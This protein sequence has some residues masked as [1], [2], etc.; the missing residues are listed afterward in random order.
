MVHASLLSYSLPSTV[1]LHPSHTY[2]LSVPRLTHTPISHCLL[3]LPLLPS[4]VFPPPLPYL[5]SHVFSP[6]A[7]HL[8]HPPRAR[9]IHYPKN[10][11]EQHREMPPDR[12]NRHFVALFLTRCALLHAGTCTAY[13][14]VFIFVPP[15]VGNRQTLDWTDRTDLMNAVWCRAWFVWLARITRQRTCGAYLPNHTVAGI[16]AHWRLFATAL[17]GQP[18]FCACW[19]HA[20]VLAAVFLSSC[21]FSNTIFWTEQLLPTNRSYLLY[22]RPP[23]HAI[24]LSQPLPCQR[25][26]LTGGDLC[27]C[28]ARHTDAPG[29]MRVGIPRTLCCAV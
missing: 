23:H 28:V 24:F 14:F 25:T 19:G 2:L 16:T 11:S 1:L 22:S 15:W 5:S 27:L 10:I 8:L 6:A 29:F 13:L 20:T 17:E 3:F 21:C 12:T 9:H 4:S 7:N 26:S 18:Q